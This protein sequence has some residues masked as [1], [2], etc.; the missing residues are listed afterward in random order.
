[1][2]VGRIVEYYFSRDFF[3][4]LKLF[5]EVPVIFDRGFH[6]TKLLGAQSHGHGFLRDFAG[7]LVA[8]T[9]AGPMGAI[10]HR[11]LA[12]IAHLT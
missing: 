6:V 9:A 1:M 10:L 2:R 5:S 7:P 8:R 4:F 12:E 11:T 3:H